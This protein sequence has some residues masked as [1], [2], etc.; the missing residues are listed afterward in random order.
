MMRRLVREET[1]PANE[2]A[3]SGDANVIHVFPQLQSALFF[4]V[5]NAQRAL[6][7]ARMKR[8]SRFSSAIRAFRAANFAS[9]KRES[10]PSL[11]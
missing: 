2:S 3:S 8:L 4:C 11:G 7:V 1:Q 5:Q 6:T 9:A 10:L